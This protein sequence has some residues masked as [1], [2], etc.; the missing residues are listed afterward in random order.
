MIILLD[1]NIVR[2]KVLIPVPEKEWRTPSQAQ[3]K[4]VFGVENHTRFHIT[5]RL[6][7]GHPVW[8][9]IFESRNDFDAFIW[10]ILTKKLKYQSAL[11]SL[12]TPSWNPELGVELTY[13]WAVSQ[14]LTSP[15]GSLQTYTFPTDYNSLSNSI[16]C[17]GGG[18][19]G[20]VCR[21]GS[22]RGGLGGGGG[23]YAKALNVAGIGTTNYQIGA[24]GTAVTS[25]GTLAGNVGGATWFG[26]TTV[27][28]NSC[29][30]SFGLAGP[31][32]TS[33][34]AIT[35]GLGGAGLIGST[36]FTGGTG[37]SKTGTAAIAFATG[38]GGA[39]GPTSAGNNGVST[40]ADGGTNGGAG[41][42]PSG[43]TAGTAST[44]A[45]NATAGAGG[46]G[47]GISASP[48]IGSGGGGG[49]NRGSDTSSTAT[50]GA[51]GNYGGGGGGACRLNNTGNP[52]SGAGIQG[53]IAVT[54]TPK[55]N[56]FNLPIIGS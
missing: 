2:T 35:G 46:A 26:G 4:D 37:G 20:G 50:G 5:A 36:L 21:S 14:Y 56:L 55:V 49:G 6:N 17:I 44:G 23:G 12:P 19:S 28:S 9:G 24:G 38:G 25:T 54:Y 51:G 10:A 33:T 34:A 32:T 16:E 42:T 52:T 18:G 53:V 15:T 47:S 27:I 29:A 8:C 43:G 48:V 41:G 40:S 39:A 45:T 11:W 13:I 31:A 1:K 30:A 3:P 7:D 22:T